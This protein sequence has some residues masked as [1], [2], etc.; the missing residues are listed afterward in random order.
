MSTTFTIWSVLLMHQSCYAPYLDDKLESTGS[1]PLS[2]W[3]IIRR[4]IGLA[5]VLCLNREDEGFTNGQSLLFREMIYDS[6]QCI[7]PGYFYFVV[8]F[9]IF[10]L[11]FEFNA[12]LSPF[13]ILYL[14][15]EDTFASQSLSIQISLF[16][17]SFLEKKNATNGIIL[18]LCMCQ[19]H[20]G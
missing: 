20:D 16:F 17:V 10:D 14:L 4:A 12:H 15:Y 1:A 18:L 13:E 9:C 3:C 6:N 2:F 7:Y 5:D 19:H 11:V 8:I